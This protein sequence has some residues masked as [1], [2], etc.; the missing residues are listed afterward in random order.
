LT[1]DLATAIGPITGTSILSPGHVFATVS[2]GSFILNS[3]G[4]VTFTATGGTAVPEPSS[5][6]LCGLGLLVG[7]SLARRR[8]ARQ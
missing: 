5:F 3:A 6:V 1:Y 7:G 8:L 2:G 4:D